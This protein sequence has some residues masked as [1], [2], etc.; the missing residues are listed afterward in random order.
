MD[1]KADRGMA[2]D[3]VR[4][5]EV[6]ILAEGHGILKTTRFE[7]RRFDGTWQTLNRETYSSG[8]GC[9]VLAYDPGRGRVLLVRQFRFPAYAA[10]H[11]TP[12]V[13]VIAG[14]VD[15]NPPDVAVIKEAREEAGVVLRTVRPVFEAFMSPGAITERLSFFVAE[16]DGADRTG[17]GGGLPGEGED[18]EVLEPTGDEAM[19]MIGDGRIVYAKTIMLLQHARLTGL[20]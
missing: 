5:L 12:L 4:I 13:E 20:I 16:Y 15:E 3:E 2:G 17:A 10:G 18:I 1:D 9:A 11:L 19:A 8:D 14:L 7:H 6:R